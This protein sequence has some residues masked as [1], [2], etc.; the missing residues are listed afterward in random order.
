MNTDAAAIA[1]AERERAADSRAGNTRAPVDELSDASSGSGRDSTATVNLRAST[2]AAFSGGTA[3]G[4]SPIG[5]SPVW[6]E[7]RIYSRPRSLPIPRAGRG[8]G[9]PDSRS[10]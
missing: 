8:A 2:G 1:V 4:L 5:R 10:T 3:G 6:L 7:P 9:Q